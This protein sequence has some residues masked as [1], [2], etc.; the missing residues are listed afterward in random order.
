MSLLVVTASACVRPP[1][2]ITPAA[3][4]VPLRTR[5]LAADGSELA[6]LFTEN[7]EPVALEGISQHLIDATIAAEDQR[8]WTHKGFDIKGIARA[9][10]A[11]LSRHKVVQGASTI[12][13]QYVKNI[14]FPKD[15]QRTFA[16]KVKEAEIAWKLESR[17]TK[18]QILERY[19]NTIYF[20]D[21]TYGVAAAA[22]DYFAKPPGTLTVAEGA[23]L[24]GMIRSPE[25]HDPR[26]FGDRAVKR[27][28]HVLLRMRALNM[29]D[30]ATYRS[31]LGEP[32]TIAPNSNFES[33]EPYFVDFLKSYVLKDPAFGFDEA[34]RAAFLYRSGATI[35][36]TLDPKMQAI[37]RRSIDKIL[38]R[39]GDPEA[40]LVAIEPKT[41]HIVAMI[42]GRDFKASQVN[43]AT[44]RLGG[45]LGRQPGSS[46]KPFV[47]ATAIE[48]GKTPG[49]VYSSDPPSIRVSRTEVWR[50]QNNEG[51]GGG[52]MTLETAMI[53]SVNAVY[54]RLGFD[55][56]PARVAATAKR[57]GI[58]TSILTPRPS[59]ALG[60]E[61]VSVLEMA[62][63][64]STLAD[65][66]VHIQPSPIAAINAYKDAP[67]LRPKLQRVLDPGTAY[68]VTDVLTKV[69]TMGTGTRAQLDRPAAGKT[70]TSQDYT[71]AWFVGYTPDLVTAVWVGYPQGAIP[72]RDVHG[73]R[74]FGG[75]FPAMI[76]HDFMQQSLAGT[77]P[78]AFEVPSSD[79][80]DVDIDPATGLLAG[81]YCSGR[82]TIRILR[83]LAPT[84]TCPSPPAGPP[85]PSP[86]TSTVT[87]EA[88]PSAQPSGPPS[89]SPSAQASP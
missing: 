47:L 44:G 43:L 73:I 85:S 39:P 13:E 38:D 75:T 83:Q 62:S 80:I 76:W 74:V 58:D 59:I 31:A 17:M 20:G 88:S 66:G 35:R 67:L 19:L 1:T 40:A 56:G 87:P 7:R 33:R 32:L 10:I 45:G 50:P 28:N 37:A 5:V 2:V 15:R 11:N 64:Y 30:E 70:G 60:S 77:A 65:L 36:T 12:T 72:M 8:F 69:I 41:G 61:E 22:E 26:R 82:Q 86:V 49:S 21:G 79:V 48:D 55:V 25:A 54:A 27:R 4:Q 42:G 24:A 51:H 68:L 81:P 18:R 9:A 14:Y 63:A 34:E 71:D 52:P 29:I 89:P 16:Q 78:S 53:Y 3:G 46:F 23:L 57:M 84:T 6:T